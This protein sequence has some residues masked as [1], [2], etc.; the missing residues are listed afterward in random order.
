MKKMPV[1]PNNEWLAMCGSDYDEFIWK[2][3][4]KKFS[5][6]MGKK[7]IHNKISLYQ[8]VKKYGVI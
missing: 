3:N 2:I 5:E 6:K 7:F 1:K 8:Y 4:N